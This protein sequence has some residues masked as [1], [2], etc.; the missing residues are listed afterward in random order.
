MI[1]HILTVVFANII[2]YLL[3][4]GFVQSYFGKNIREELSR[5]FNKMS[6][7]WKKENTK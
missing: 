1:K 2:S 7:H 3:Y 5:F 4:Q 6:K